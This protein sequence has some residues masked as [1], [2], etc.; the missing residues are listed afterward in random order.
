MI[1]QTNDEVLRKKNEL[2]DIH[3]EMDGYRAQMKSI[4]A[5]MVELLDKME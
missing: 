1:R 5:R 3:M 4:C 2:A